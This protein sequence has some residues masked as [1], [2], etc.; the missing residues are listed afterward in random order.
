MGAAPVSASLPNG[1]TIVQRIKVF[2]AL[3][4]PTFES[5][6][7]SSGDVLLD[8]KVLRF[9]NEGTAIWLRF[10]GE[11][12]RTEKESARTRRAERARDQRT[13]QHLA[14]TEQHRQ[15]ER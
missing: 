10:T 4:S 14:N 5:D 3:R 7:H 11:S 15:W 1:L 8:G 6:D 12:A 9:E 13:A 2:E